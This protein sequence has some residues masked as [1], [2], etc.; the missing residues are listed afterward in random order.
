MN[1]KDKSAADVGAWHIK[2][3]IAVT[4]FVV[5][6]FLTE[7]I[8]L[9]AVAFCIGLA[10]VFTGVVSRTEVTMLYWSDALLV[11]HGQPHV[12]GRLCQKPAWTSASA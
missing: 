8:P 4:A 1:E 7:C 2:V 10:F 12:R 6:C 3:A 11:Y 9:P 5:L